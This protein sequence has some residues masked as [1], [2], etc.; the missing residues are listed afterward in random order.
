M[1]HQIAVKIPNQLAGTLLLNYGANIDLKD[2]SGKTAV[3]LAA[4]QELKDVI[5]NHMDGS[6]YVLK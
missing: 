5:Q 6:S 3:K 2:D 1:I 4:T